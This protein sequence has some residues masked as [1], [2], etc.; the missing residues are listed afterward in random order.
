MNAT[1]L[2]RKLQPEGTRM[3]SEWIRED[4]VKVLEKC[5]DERTGL[6]IMEVAEVIKEVW[7]AEDIKILKNN[8]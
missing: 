7:A 5:R 6:A 4:L 8:L 3:M 1:E 2:R